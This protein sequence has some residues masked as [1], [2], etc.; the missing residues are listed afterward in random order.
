MIKLVPAWT[1]DY[2]EYWKSIENRNLWFI[3]L[4][5]GAF[6]MLVA[7]LTVAIYLF[8][9]T[10]SNIQIYWS[11]GISLSILF[12]NIILHTFRSK[13]KR[14]PGKFNQLHYSLIQMILDLIAL[15]L[16]IYFSGSIET[17]LYMLYIFHMI[18][19]SLILPGRVIFVLSTATILIFS[20]IVILEFFG[21]I[22]HYH[23]KEIY[24]ADNVHNVR[25]ILSSLGIFIFTIYTSI[26]I[27][28]RIAKRLYKRE[29][30]LKETLEALNKAEEAK[31][32]YIMAV[33]HEIKSPIVATQS[34]IELVKKG[35]VGDITDKIE[36]KLTRSIKRTEDALNLINNILRISKLK[37]LG[38]ISYDKVDALKIINLVSDH[39]LDLVRR[40]NINYKVRD[41]RRVKNEIDSDPVMIELI[42]SNIIGNAVKYTLE[43]E[44]VLIELKED[45]NLLVIEISDSGI[46][47]PKDEIDKVFKQFYRAKNLSGQKFEGSG[48]GLSL[49]KEIVERLDGSII[50]NSPSKIGNA[51]NPGVTVTITLPISK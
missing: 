46:G 10:L 2:D 11:L 21:I 34:I 30:Q 3:H 44:R 19:G 16:I 51:E 18:I 47:I 17:P 31:Q 36:E 39:H 15:T 33:V 26:G 28:S 37:L 49:V 8:E 29:K 50:V 38:E 40:K 9:L 20:G 6:L 25:F 24:T 12:Y 43:N 5:Y 13:I 4:R 1:Y 41:L 14:T 32:K 45:N 7:M 22:P 48:L 27:T 42:F 23:I 35:Y